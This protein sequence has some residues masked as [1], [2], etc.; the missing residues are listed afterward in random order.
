MTRKAAAYKEKRA[1]LDSYFFLAKAYM[2]N[3][4]LE[5]ALNTFQIF[6]KLATDLGG[7]GGMENFTYVDQQIQAC[8]NGMNKM[9]SPF[10]LSKKGL[11]QGF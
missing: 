11:G 7:K 1:P 3:N 9:P 8:I 10:R 5:K 2:I 6:K 4:E